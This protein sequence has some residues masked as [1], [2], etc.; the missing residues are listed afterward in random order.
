MKSLGSV[1]GLTRGAG[2]SLTLNQSD[3]SDSVICVLQYTTTS[4]IHIYSGA[5]GQKHEGFDGVISGQTGCR[6]G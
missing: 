1:E 2:R 4:K 6:Q 5:H 3:A